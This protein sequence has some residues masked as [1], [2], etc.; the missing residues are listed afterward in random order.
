MT[1]TSNRGITV[2]QPVLPI[3]L[4]GLAFF[5]LSLGSFHGV[6]DDLCQGQVTLTFYRGGTRLATATVPGDRNLGGF[7][8]PTHIDRQP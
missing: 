8:I 1:A 2:S 6:C 3:K 5:A 4:H 7:P